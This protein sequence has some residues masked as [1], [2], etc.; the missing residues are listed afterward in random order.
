[1]RQCIQIGLAASVL[2]I[3]ENHNGANAIAFA[4]VEQLSRS[5]DRI[6]KRG[7]AI[8]DNGID[9]AAYC[10]FHLLKGGQ[11]ILLHDLI[12]K[13]NQRDLVLRRQ[14]IEEA[15]GCGTCLLN[16]RPFH[17]TGDIDHQRNVGLFLHI[18][19]TGLDGGDSF[20]A[21]Y[22]NRRG[23]LQGIDAQFFDKGISQLDRE[24]DGA[25]PGGHHALLDRRA[26][27]KVGKER[28]R[29]ALLGTHPVGVGDAEGVFVPEGAFF[30]VERH[31]LLRRFVSGFAL[32]D[33]DQIVLFQ[34]H[35][36]EIA[37]T[38]GDILFEFGGALGVMFNHL[39]NLA[40]ADL[41]TGVLHQFRRQAA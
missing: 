31:Q 20:G 19:P 11:F 10:A 34:R 29:R 27:N 18:L 32:V 35:K 3:T 41:D 1:M 23:R 39:L 40:H 17:R 12:I 30:G 37:G 13:G 2:P 15:L 26:T 38:L 33:V 16:L 25:E 24:I 8:G 14:Q 7:A 9:L 4:L 36:V 22:I 6:V 5:G 21:R 28:G